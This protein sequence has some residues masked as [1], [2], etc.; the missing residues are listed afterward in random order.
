MRVKDR[1]ENVQKRDQ[2]AN[3]ALRSAFRTLSSIYG[4]VFVKIVNGYKPLNIFSKKL[5]HR[6]LIGS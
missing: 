3:T 4:R 2:S 6:C 1:E 5:R